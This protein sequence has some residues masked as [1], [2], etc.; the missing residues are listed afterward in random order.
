MFG[1]FHQ[2]SYVVLDFVERFLVADSVS[3]LVISLFRFSMSS[4]FILDRLYISRNV[5]IFL[6]LF[7]LLVYNC[8]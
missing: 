1:G 6:R 3:L 4:R 5:F 7:N 2:R 8:S